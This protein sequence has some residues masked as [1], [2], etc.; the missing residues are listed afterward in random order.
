MECFTMLKQKAAVAA[1]ACGLLYFFSTSAQAQVC[2]VDVAKVFE[3]HPGFNSRLEQLKQAAEEYKLT[4]QRRGEEL[5]T[6]SEE[7]KAYKVGSEEY[8]AL[9]TRLAQASASLEVERTNKTR[10][11]IQAE[12]KL[13]FDTYVQVTQAISS[14]CEQRGYRAALRF[15]NTAM[16]PGN[17]QSI[18]QK[19]N[20][21]VVFH[22]PQIDITREIMTAVGGSVPMVGDR[23]DG[24]NNK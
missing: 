6:Q 15:S 14:L 17:P 1:M 4:L 3:S 11:F 10:E 22:Q 7:L 8:K 20:D 24:T 12:A 9:E 19:V 21:Y 2:V 13:H 5:K 18:M 23:P 16:D